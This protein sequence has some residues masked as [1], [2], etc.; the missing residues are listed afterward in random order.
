MPVAGEHHPAF[1]EYCECIYEMREDNADIIQARLAERLNVS[2]ASVSEMVKRMEVAGL[3][4]VN[5]S[6]LTL[7]AKGE[8]LA[9]QIVRRH[10]LAERFLTDV[11]G[12]PWAR[13]HHEAC[14]WEHVISDDVEEGLV[15][16][17]G[18]PTT[19][20]H[21]NPIPG[22]VPSGVAVTPLAQVA[23]GSRFTVVRIPEEVEERDG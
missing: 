21:G 5:P 2:R 13:A 22:S 9:S 17:L 12:L 8:D 4:S 11:I 7:T 23:V 1:E 14:K 19:C 18:N 15:R 3:L 20:P 16:I 10:R 6:H